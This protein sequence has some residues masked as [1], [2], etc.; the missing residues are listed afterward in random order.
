MIQ[1]IHSLRSLLEDENIYIR[2]DIFERIKTDVTKHESDKFHACLLLDEH[3]EL[4]S[5]GCNEYYKGQSFPFTLHAE[6]NCINRFYSRKMKQKNSYIKGRKKILIIIRLSK[7]ILKLGQSKP[8]TR[9][10]NFI[11]NN[12]DNLNLKKIIYSTP[13]GLS[14][15]KSNKFSEI[16]TIYS[17]GSRF[18]VKDVFD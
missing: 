7:K 16:D 5:Y 10:H 15:V 12:I 4:L 6:I 17:S 9:C 18:K 8:C 3:G 11:E 2:D 1:G 13:A 14:V